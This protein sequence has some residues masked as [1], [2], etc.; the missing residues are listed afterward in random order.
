[1]RI[2][3][4]LVGRPPVAEAPERHERFKRR[5]LRR[6]LAAP[7]GP[8]YTQ[9]LEVRFLHT[10][11]TPRGVFVD[12]GANA[13]A[14]AV[15]A[16]Q[17][18]GSRSLVLVEPLPS[19]A[20]RLRERFPAS[21]VVNAALSDRRGTATIRIP[22][23]DGKAYDTRATLNDHDE[24]GQSGADEPEV[25]LR[26]LDDVA[27][28]LRLRRI[29]VLKVDVEGHEL[30]LLAGGR[31]TIARPRPVVLIEIEARHHDFPLTDIFRELESLGLAGWVFDPR[32]M[33]VRRARDLD[34]AVDQDLARLEARDF[35][36]YLNN[37]WFVPRDRE[38]DFLTQARAFLGGLDPLD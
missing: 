35:L 1:M 29:D 10:Y 25:E 9:D 21:R 15:V 7:V 14:Y 3:V 38:D 17:S 30:E 5:V 22:S 12:V 2:R 33:D 24:P 26:T 34:V 37:F 31:E 23:I 19:L 6:T 11:L 28:E 4:P 32:T 18:V 36:R 27:D 20:E 16:E 13:G 8:D